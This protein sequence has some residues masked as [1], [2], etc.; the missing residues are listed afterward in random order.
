MNRQILAIGA[1]TLLLFAATLAV[2]PAIAEERNTDEREKMRQ[3]KERPYKMPITIASGHGGAIGNDG[4]EIHRSHIL[5]AA[6][7]NDNSTQDTDFIVKRG[8]LFIADGDRVGKYEVVPDTWKVQVR[9]D[10]NTFSAEGKVQDKK[11]NRYSVSLSG[12]L[13]GNT[14][15][16]NLYFVKGKLN[17]NSGE[18]DTYKLYYLM[19][20]HDKMMV[21]KVKQR[22]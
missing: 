16:G 17:G 12:E 15:N 8:G 20:V 19:I 9:K 6:V 21:D 3:F 7:K 2:T 5:I 13:L 11:D 4:N 14:K 10:S 22:E 1:A 18:G